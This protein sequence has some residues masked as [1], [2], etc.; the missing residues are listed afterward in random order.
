MTNGLT[1]NYCVIDEKL[2]SFP[3]RIFS[4]RTE[5]REKEYGGNPLVGRHISC[6]SFYFP[7]IVSAA[8][9]RESKETTMN[10]VRLI[11]S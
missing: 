2:N 11:P 5:I 4:W 10:C 3:L 9:N 1:G 7:T 8:E 6:S